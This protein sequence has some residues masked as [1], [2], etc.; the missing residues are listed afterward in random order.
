MFLSICIPTYNRSVLLRQTL[1]VLL[2]QISI[3]DEIEVIISDNASPDDT[4]DVVAALLP[5]NPFIRYIRN[6]TNIGADD[7]AM[8]CLR[9]AEGDYV[10]FCSDDDIPL[11][12]IVAKVVSVLTQHKP[13][14]VFLNHTGFIEGEPYTA[15]YERGRELPDEI[16]TDGEEMLLR[17]VVNHFSA[18]IL[19]RSD[20][21]KHLADVAECRARG[22]GQG[23]A[24][25]VLTQEVLLD[26]TLSGVCVYIGM[27]GLA[28]NN[29]KEIT[30]DVVKVV[31]IDVVNQW[32]R[33]RRLGK[34]SKDTER[35]LANWALSSVYHILIPT[36]AKGSPELSL[37]REIALAKL[38]WRYP[39]FYTRVLPILLVPRV[40]WIVL[41]FPARWVVRQLVRVPSFYRW[42][43]SLLFNTGAPS[44]SGESQNHNG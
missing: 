22:F 27:N 14:L 20:T 7:N 44:V 19:R 10:W 4:R 23:Y 43:H 15:A 9:A 24:R 5:K 25:G 36:K 42:Y 17:R 39:V 35:K 29:P 16:Y 21:E 2:P 8:E 31:I 34:I 13:R 1:D 12:G 11:P 40:V 37:S 18:T 3:A 28:V 41:F 33:L 32:Q 38:L 26:R 6:E 30:Y